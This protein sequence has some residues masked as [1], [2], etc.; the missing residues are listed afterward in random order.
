MTHY[1][2]P[3][4]DMLALSVLNQIL[5]QH[6]VE[7]GSMVECCFDSFSKAEADVVSRLLIRVATIHSYRAEL[8]VTK[9]MLAG[10]RFNHRSLIHTF[11]IEGS[12]LRILLAT[13]GI[14]Q[15]SIMAIITGN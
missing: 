9:S 5:D 2:L 13:T 12:I 10:P 8:S 1:S 14:K 11:C 3:E 7:K 6:N 15:V 4:L